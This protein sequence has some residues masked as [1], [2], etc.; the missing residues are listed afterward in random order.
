MHSNDSTDREVRGPAAGPAELSPAQ[1]K[2]ASYAQE[3]A[4]DRG[5]TPGAVLAALRQVPGGGDGSADFADRWD[6][7]VAD[8]DRLAAVLIAA[9]G[10][11]LADEP[12]SVWNRGGRQGFFEPG[13]A[14]LVGDD[15]SAGSPGDLLPA[16]PPAAA[17]LGDIVRA[18][19]DALE[20]LPQPLRWEWAKH[21]G[22]G[23]SVHLGSLA[24]L[25]EWAR[26]WGAEPPEPTEWRPITGGRSLCRQH[27]TALVR[28]GQCVDLRSTELRAEPETPA[29]RHE[30]LTAELARLDDEAPAC[31]C[32]GRHWSCPEPVE[33]GE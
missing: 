15:P 3:V 23:V 25:V 1:R 24:D 8:L 10:L 27:V 21:G 6:M 29:E 4:R 13:R 18:L 14:P 2:L 17:A 19:A 12:E 28:A 11:D 9:D 26:W 33:G 31:G 22:S 16:D 32:G 7:T 30:R 5:K 20:V